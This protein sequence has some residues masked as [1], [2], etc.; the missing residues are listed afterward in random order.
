MSTGTLERVA[1]SKIVESDHNPRTV[2]NEA[3]LAELTESIKASGVLQP[4][5]L[6]K[7]GGAKFELVDGKRRVAA[8]RNAKVKDVPAFIVGE[9][10]TREMALVANLQREDLTPL[11]EANAL[12]Q[13]QQETKESARAIAK[14]I[15]KSNDYVSDRLRLVKLPDEVKAAVETGALG[16]HAIPVIARIA[17]AAPIAAAAIVEDLVGTDSEFVPREL[18]DAKMVTTIIDDTLENAGDRT[19]DLWKLAGM[20]PAVLAVGAEGAVIDTAA[21]LTTRLKRVTRALRGYESDRIQF[22]D[23]DVDAARAFG[24]LFVVEATDWQGRVRE[25]PYCTDRDWLV[26]RIRLKI[27]TLE[28]EATKKGKKLD[29]TSGGAQP[30]KDVAAGDKD[31]VADAKE[32]RRKEREKEER[33]RVTARGHNLALGVKL[34]KTYKAPKLTADNVRLV[35]EL[36]LTQ[37]M[38]IAHRGLRY[39]D[40]RLQ[41]VETQKNGKQKITYADAPAAAKLLR[42]DLDKAKTPEEII[43][44]VLKA[45]AAAHYASQDVV[46]Q[47]SRSYFS[48]PGTSSFSANNHVGK[49]I[50]KVADKLVPPALKKGAGK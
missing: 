50:A 22:D 14:R 35:A 40:E 5:L 11:E 2:L 31:A 47:S 20:S 48:I 45:L 34:A 28:A 1:L 49:L 21:E 36:A 9:G 42:E 12:Y 30:S 8:A 32:Q 16:L 7:N 15:G 41:T 27:D 39:V 37:R 18:E 13:L 43:G 38:D 23:D 6:K 3:A 33:A 44:V 19:L 46:A 10:S 24:C 29:A 25:T 4:V 17:E 26:D